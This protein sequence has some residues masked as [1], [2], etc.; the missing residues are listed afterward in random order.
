MQDC[1]VHENTV[2]VVLHIYFLVFCQSYWTVFLVRS[3]GNM[4][5]LVLAIPTLFS[6]LEDYHIENTIFIAIFV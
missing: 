6:W 2:T 4:L 1:Y 3:E 5:Q